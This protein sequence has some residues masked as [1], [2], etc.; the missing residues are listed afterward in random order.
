[1]ACSLVNTHTHTHTHRHTDRQR[2]QRRKEPIPRGINLAVY[3]LDTRSNS[4]HMMLTNKY[5][6]ENNLLAVPFDKG[7]GICLMTRETYNNKMKL[8]TDL[9]QFEKV[10]KKRID[11]KNPVLK[12]EDNVCELLKK[13]YEEKKL[14]KVMHDRLRPIGSQPPRLYGLAKVHKPNTPMRPVLSMPGSAYYEIAKQ[15]ATWLSFVP[16]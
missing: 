1:M 2:K 11:A 6:K 14:S 8:L 13:L 7:I 9:P 4:R 12:E 10:V 3:L 15:I 16:E 5:L